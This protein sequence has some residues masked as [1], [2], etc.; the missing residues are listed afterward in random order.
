MTLTKSEYSEM[1]FNVKLSE[2]ID[3]HHAPKPKIK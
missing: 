2:Y 1:I 3:I